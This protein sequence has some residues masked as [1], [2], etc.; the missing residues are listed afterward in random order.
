MT[1]AAFWS[2]I[3]S[4]LRSKS[5]RWAPVHQAKRSIRRDSQ[6]SN[7]R[8]R[9]EYQ[10]AKCGGWFP[11]KETVVDHIVPVGGLRCYGDLPGVVERMFCE[12]NG[13]QVLCKTDHNIK[14]QA[15]IQQIKEQRTQS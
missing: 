6:S 11:D 9:F 14:T 7:P 1:E 3:K 10:C 5:M 13:F 8:L 4:A 15:D 12:K 2:F